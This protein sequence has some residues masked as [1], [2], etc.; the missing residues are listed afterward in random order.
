MDAGERLVARDLV[1]GG[2]ERFDERGE[3]AH[4]ERWVGFP[5]RTKVGLH[6][7]VELHGAVL[8]PDPASLLRGVRE[9]LGNSY[10]RAAVGCKTSRD[11]LTCASYEH[12][13]HGVGKPVLRFQVRTFLCERAAGAYR[14]VA[15]TVRAR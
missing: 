13:S 9:R 4:G 7:E 6:A 2:S 11:G 8:E 10:S 5:G 3:V 14:G 12:R 1:P 15:R